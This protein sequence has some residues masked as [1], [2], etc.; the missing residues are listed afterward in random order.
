MAKRLWNVFLKWSPTVDPN[1]LQY[2]IQ[3]TFTAS[4]KLWSKDLKCHWPSFKVISFRS[5]LSF[6]WANKYLAIPLTLTNVDFRLGGTWSVLLAL[7]LQPTG[8][9][10]GWAASIQPWIQKAHACDWPR[11][12]F[13]LPTNSRVH[14]KG[15]QFQLQR[16]CK[17][18]FATNNLNVGL[19]NERPSY[20]CLLLSGRNSQL[21]VRLHMLP[22]DTWLYV[23]ESMRLHRWEFAHVSTFTWHG[24]PPPLSLTSI[25]RRAS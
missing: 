4:T 9:G 3:C 17:T 6:S 25:N 24:N 13:K 22:E 2:S 5:F 11:F 23:G 21:Q 16:H 19:L 15:E 12:C 1:S 8:G 20:E 7:I 18:W 14:I 10:N